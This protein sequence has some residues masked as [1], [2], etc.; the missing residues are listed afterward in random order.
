MNKE[1]EKPKVLYHYCSVEAF[2]NII[3]NHSIWLSDL[4][5][6]NDSKELIWVK[7]A[8]ERVVTP[9][10]Q[11]RIQPEDNDEFYRHEYVKAFLNLVGRQVFCWGFCL[12]EKDDNLGQWRGYGD[13]GTGICI[14]FDF[15]TLNELIPKREV[16]RT[17]GPILTLGKICYKTKEEMNKTLRER[18]QNI[19]SNEEKRT[20]IG[21]LVNATK[22]VSS[23]SGFEIPKV[24]LLPKTEG[25]IAVT[26]VAMTVFPFYKSE[27]FEEEAE[28]RI[29]FSIPREEFSIKEFE[30]Y[31]WGSKLEFKEFKFNEE[32]F[33]S[34]LDIEFV[35][36][37]DVIKS[38]TIGPKSKL[39]K[40]EVEL[41]LRW[42]GVYSDDIEI[43]K[44]AA[45]Y[46]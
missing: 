25:S 19:V 29:V 41:I 2:Y 36:I 26:I 15:K 31:Q 46:W 20:K 32:T 11:E 28:Y 42:Y 7:E 13:D 12:S 18:A 17:G 35:D 24:Q 8:A 30:E 43:K 4:T 44:S 22:I 23:G 16:I 14:G 27:G 9:Y 45:T 40:Q 39:T 33:V 34:H 1:G 5:N 6:T 38:I 37:K 3:K 10:I 21:E